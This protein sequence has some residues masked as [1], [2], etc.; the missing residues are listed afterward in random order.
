A[1]QI[2]LAVD[3]AMLFE[4]VQ[5][6]SQYD[7]LTKLPVRRYFMERL[8]EEVYRAERFGQPVSL[9]WM[10]LDHFKEIN[11]TYGHQTGDVVLKEVSRMIMSNLRKIDM[12]C[13]YGGDEIVI[14]LPQSRLDEA[15][16]IAMRLS[17]EASEIRV[18]GAMA[19]GAD[20]RVSV[21]QG[22]ATIPGDASSLDELM[23]HA[24][25]ALYWVK[26]NG[27]GGGA[28]YGEVLNQLE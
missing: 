6:L 12:P 7:E 23:K 5:E 27:R 22:V 8:Q 26:T 24:D 19:G 21:S 11:D 25:E 28:V 9:I 20:L 17:R 14:M 1:G 2:A 13:R 18:P 10:D 16:A 4:R 3:N 15:K